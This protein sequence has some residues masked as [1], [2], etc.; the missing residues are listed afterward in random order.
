M[1][2]SNSW[3][4]SPVARSPPLT[5]AAARGRLR[6]QLLAEAAGAGGQR[7]GAS[8]WLSTAWM[9]TAGPCPARGC[10]ASPPACPSGPRRGLRVIVAG[11]PDPPVPNDVDADHPLRGCRIRR[12]EASPHAAEVTRLA[13]RELVEVLATDQDRHNGLGYEVLGLVAACGGGLDRR[14]LQQL[15]RRRPS[16]STGYCAACSA[17]PSPTGPTRIPPP[18]VPVH[19]RDPARTGHRPSRP[20]TLA[21]FATR[22]HTW[23]DGYQQ[24]GWPADTP[25]YLLRGYSRVLADAGDLDRLVALA[26]DSSPP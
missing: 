20:E 7:P 4:R 25:A 23:A 22:L 24:R 6:R 2:C 17:A 9:G 11:R 12:L 10:P 16:R 19:P 1:P 18:G 5:S 14:D 13:Q 15:D 26:T 3:P 21:G 8:C